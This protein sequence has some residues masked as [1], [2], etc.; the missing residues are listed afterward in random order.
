MD[1]PHAQ[2]EVA[3]GFQ[4][5]DALSVQVVGHQRPDEA[6]VAGITRLLVCGEG[7]RVVKIRVD[8]RHRQRDYAPRAQLL[9]LDRVIVIIGDHQIVQPRCG[10]LDRAR[11]HDR[12]CA[13]RIDQRRVVPPLE[14][15][16]RLRVDDPVIAGQDDQ[17]RLEGLRHRQQIPVA[18]PEIGIRGGHTR[19][20]R[21]ER[22]SR[23][24]ALGHAQLACLCPGIRALIAPE[25]GAGMPLLAERLHPE[26]MALRRR[27]DRVLA[28]RGDLPGLFQLSGMVQG[29]NEQNAHQSFLACFMAGFVNG[30]MA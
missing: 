23:R 22:A 29:G 15:F 13:A 14:C 30:F 3:Q 21:V 10:S 11:E 12:G 5:G 26:K 1:A 16:Q 28:G 6:H 25:H 24:Q 27:E 9:P 19:Q 7:W 20:C 8:G 2:I 4:R 17:V 18:Q